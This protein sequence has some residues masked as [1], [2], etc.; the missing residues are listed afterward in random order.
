M[1]TAKRLPQFL[2]R[3]RARPGSFSVSP[4]AVARIY[5]AGA[6]PHAVIKNAGQAGYFAVA[7]RTVAFVFPEFEVNGNI[8]LSYVIRPHMSESRAQLPFLMFA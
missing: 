4:N 2:V 1:C 3:N 8:L 6:N 7:G 5:L